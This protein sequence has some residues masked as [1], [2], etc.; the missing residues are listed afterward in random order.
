M[1]KKNVHFGHR[2][3][4]EKTNFEDTIWLFH[5]GSKEHI[6]RMPE[7]KF[8]VKRIKS[9]GE[10]AQNVFCHILHFNLNSLRL[11]GWGAQNGRC[12]L[13]FG[14]SMQLWR[15]ISPSSGN[16][17][18]SIKKYVKRTHSK[19]AKTTLTSI[20]P[21]CS[22]CTECTRRGAWIYAFTQRN[23]AYNINYFSRIYTMSCINYKFCADARAHG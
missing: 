17:F 13:K 3:Q 23:K 14:E 4:I 18:T 11:G 20:W 1:V 21:R 10:R 7:L 12:W 6:S 8:Q 16:I 9:G 2:G 5:A 15:Q 22:K 19:N